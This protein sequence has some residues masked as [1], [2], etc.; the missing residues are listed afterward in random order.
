MSEEIH[1]IHEADVEIYFFGDLS[2]FVQVPSHFSW[3]SY[4]PKTLPV[5][6]V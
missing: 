2:L 3:P 1:T 4:A 6:K 5:Q